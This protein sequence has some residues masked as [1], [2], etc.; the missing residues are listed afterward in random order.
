[1][2]ELSNCTVFVV[3]DTEANIDTLVETL[4]RVYEVSIANES[5][6]HNVLFNH[7]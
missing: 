7:T 3:D 2:K 6:V 1:M 5:N 4:D